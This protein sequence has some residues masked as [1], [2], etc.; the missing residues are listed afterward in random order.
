M[1]SNKTELLK[2]L[3]ELAWLLRR[4]SMRHL[5]EHGP[6][7]APHQGQ[8]RILALLKLK[9][10]MSQKE[11]STILDIRAQS[12]GELLAKLERSGLIERS[13]SEEDRRAMIVRLTEAGR[14]AAEQGLGFETADSL[15]DCLSA[16]EQAAFADYVRRLIEAL[17]EELGED[18]EGPRGDP[19]ARFGFGGP[20]RG[21]GG[22]IGFGGPGHRA[23]PGGGPRGGEGQ[24]L[25]GAL[26]CR[27]GMRGFAGPG[28]RPEAWMARAEGGPWARARGGFAGAE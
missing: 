12:L 28:A 20:G 5:R 17:G 6:M 8:G 26:R 7:G 25:F 4:R 22:P 1:E 27:L 18:E 24:S 19:R 13:P 2:R 11:L 23:G 21:R 10:E 9:P 3:F 15:F 16:E 14:A